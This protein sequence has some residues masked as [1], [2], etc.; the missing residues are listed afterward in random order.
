MSKSTYWYG[1]SPK[2][3]ESTKVKLLFKVKNGG[4]PKSE[5]REYWDENGLTWFTPEDVSKEG[6]NINDSKRKI[7]ILGME[8]SSANF[9]EPYSLVLSTRAPIGNLKLSTVKFTTNQGCKSL[10]GNSNVDMDYYYYFFSITKEYLNSLGQGTTFLELSNSA[11]KN[12]EVPLPDLNTQK[13]I[14][15]FL[16]KKTETIDGL[17][18]AKIKLIELLGEKRQSMITEAIT[19]GLT[20]NVKMKDSGVEWIG[21]IPESWNIKK[22][23][24]KFD[25]RKVIQSNEEPIVLSLTQKGIKVKN[26]KD[27][28]G[29]H[30]ESYDKYQQVEINDYVMNGMDLLTGYVDCA[31]FEGVTSP[32]Y[33]VFR[34]KYPEECHDYYLRYFQM[35]YFAKIFYG[36]GQGVSH[37]GRWRL[38]TDVFKGFPIPE[39][40]IDEQFEI[41]KYLNEKE[42]EINEVIEMI[43][44]QIQNLKDYRQSLI[45]EAVTGK[46]DV[47]DFEV[48][49]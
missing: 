29:Q 16:N 44:V 23:K 19:K 8:N 35:C 21:K 17:I 41:S 28:S 47:R 13:A 20:P 2:S 42:I 6:K 10:E 36:H 22:I 15:N 9:V 33:R 31:K 25:I 38:Q 26:L 12:I 30:A 5:V 43:R 4:T 11:L 37:F 32:D 49:A 45:Y 3:W 34:L 1:S 14:A 24:Y 39:P 27:F 18:Q 7:S 40:P 46:I 48:E